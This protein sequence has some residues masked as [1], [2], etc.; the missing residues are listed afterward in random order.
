MAEG[1]PL[2][3]DDDAFKS[4]AKWLANALPGTEVSY[5]VLDRETV[6]YRVHAPHAGAPRYEL[7]ISREAFEDHPVETILADLARLKIPDRLCVDPTMRLNYTRD[8]NVHHLETLW[9]TCDG[10]NYRV[11]RD[12]EHNVRIYDKA[13]QL[14]TNWP[15][16]MT[17]LPSSI[18]T[19]PVSEWCED[20]RKWRGANQ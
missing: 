10:R 8:R 14:L 9:V 17:V 7:E 20:V 6:L 15:T 12:S 2:A 3:Y 11:V 19:R 18:H 1:G 5:G 16:V 13:Q 4:V